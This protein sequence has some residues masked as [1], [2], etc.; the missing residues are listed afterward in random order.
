MNGRWLLLSVFAALAML[1]GGCQNTVNTVENADRNATPEIIADKRFI[2]DGFLENRLVLRSVHMS[3][4]ASG[5]MMVQVSATNVRTGFFSQLWSGMTG[6]NPYRVDYRFTWQ[7][8]NGMV[9]DLPLSAWRTVSI[10]PGETIQFTAI[11]PNL[12]CKDFVLNVKESE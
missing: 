8:A 3:P 7:D 2:T 4:S 10:R 6:G 9:V 1:L 11:A 5:N 12:R